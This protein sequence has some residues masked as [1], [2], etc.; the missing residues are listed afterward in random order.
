MIVKKVLHPNSDLRKGKSYDL[1]VGE[2]KGE[3]TYRI[4]LSSQ[5]KFLIKEKILK[6][7]T[8]FS[9][10]NGCITKMKDNNLVIIPTR[11]TKYVS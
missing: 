3:F 2:D 11:I 1:V 7:E 10:D 4:Y 9:I 5:L 8:V 6:K